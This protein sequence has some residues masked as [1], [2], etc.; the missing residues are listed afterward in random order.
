MDDAFAAAVIFILCLFLVALAGG[1]YTAIEVRYEC[2]NFGKTEV[3]NKWYECKP[4][5][6]EK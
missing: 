4:I 1:V 5:K 3:L 2:T 6:E